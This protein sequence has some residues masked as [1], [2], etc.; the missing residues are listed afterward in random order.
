MKKPRP[1]NKLEGIAAA[2]GVAI[3]RA[4][5]HNEEV[6]EIPKRKIA[7]DQVEG[8]A[9]RFLNTLHQVGEEIRRT[10]RLV[11][12][13]HGAELAMIFEAQLFMLEDPEIKKQTLT[14][15]RERQC[16]ADRAFSVTLRQ[17]R[18]MF[19]Q[20]E[21][22]Y[23][24]MR[25]SDVMDIEQQVLIRLAGGE[26]R[27]LCALRANT[28]VVAH[29]LLP[30]EAVELGQ[31]R[32]KGLV[33]DG[34]GANS[35][36]SIIARSLGLPTVVGTQSASHQITSG[37]M[38]VVDGEE[39]VV[40]VNPTAPIL[41]SYRGQVQRQRQRQ[42]DLNARRDLPARTRDDCEIA[43][44]ANIDV[45]EEVQAALDHGARG[46]GMYRTELLYL[47]YRLPSE[48]EQVAVYRRIVEALAPHPVV[49]RTFDLGGDKLSHVLESAPEANPFLGW[50]GIR[51][52]LDVPSL[53]KAQLRA[54]LRA[55]VKGRAQLLLPM[56][57]SLEEVR[58]AR[59]VLA[60]V[61]EELRQEGVPFAQTCE[62]GVMVEVPSVA[63]QADAF[64]AEVDFLS[65]GTNDLT[66]YTL[67]VDRGTP[68]VAELYDSFHP[69]VL[70]LVAMTVE[71]G[72]RHGVPVSICGELAGDP[73]AVPLLVG[74]GLESLSLSPGLI[75]EVKEVVRAI[76]LSEARELA[77]ACLT[78]KTGAE[79]RQR[80]EEAAFNLAK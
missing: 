48:E 78:L 60:E 51:I 30:S 65:L 4:F 35:H 38:V 16:T 68:T 28:V 53:F 3:G 10:Q 26:L 34:G 43:L 62:L 41:R 77:A 15:I 69:A 49:I 63:L 76:C 14:L 6:P 58:R 64:A 55:G 44:L 70:R 7:A 67:A 74:L 20:I 36:A 22:E 27:A 31:R 75:P 71:S 29:D 32:V 57:S 19:E 73:L 47:G 56:V 37:D 8:E 61:E 39:G 72:R 17:A 50:R 66:Q 9:E 24:R 40:H 45:P 11:E 46:V 59:Q 18:K 23:L 2:P 1:Y 80:L 25:I 33:I 5:I 13:E 79:V 12:M 42:L 52:C 54:V 21:N